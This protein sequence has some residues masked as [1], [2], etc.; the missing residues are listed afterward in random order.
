MLQGRHVDWHLALGFATHDE[1]NEEP[2]NA[3]AREVHS[4]RDDGACVRAR[5]DGYVN[6]G[7]D[8]SVNPAD[9]PPVW[10]FE[11]DELRGHGTVREPDPSRDEAAIPNLRFAVAVHPTVDDTLLPLRES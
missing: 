2:T 10:R 9:A 8:R 5:F 11:P 7:A 3:V 6:D 4:D 1:R